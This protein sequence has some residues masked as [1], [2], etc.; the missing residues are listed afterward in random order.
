VNE[1]QRAGLWAVAYLLMVGAAA[2]FTIF[3]VAFS[4]VK[5]F[6]S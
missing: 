6:W 4:F 3:A 2:Y 1:G 5:Q